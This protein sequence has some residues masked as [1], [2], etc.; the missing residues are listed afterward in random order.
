MKTLLWSLLGTF[1]VLGLL[2]LWAAPRVTTIGDGYSLIQFLNGGGSDYLVDHSGGESPGPTVTE[3]AGD[4]ASV[5]EVRTKEGKK[6]SVARNTPNQ[7]P[8]APFPA[9]L[10]EMNHAGVLIWKIRMPDDL[11]EG[12]FATT[13]WLIGGEVLESGLSFEGVP[14]GQTATVVLWTGE[15]TKYYADGFEGEPPP[16]MPYW[17]SFPGTGKSPANRHGVLTV[18]RGWEEP[19]GNLASGDYADNGWLMLRCNRKEDG[20]ES[21]FANLEFTY[22]FEP[23]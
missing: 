12:E 8:D 4:K 18:P 7:G 17:L 6:R 3:L 11:E 1:L 21:Y 23:D 10:S 16:G 5:I 19:Y 20:T 22:R 2:Y 9:T 13:E 14:A 15:H